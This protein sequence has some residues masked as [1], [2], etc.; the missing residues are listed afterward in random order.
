V[1]EALQ[2]G[3]GPGAERPIDEEALLSLAQM[4]AYAQGW[5][6]FKSFDRIQNKEYLLEMAAHI[7]HARAL[8]LGIPHPPLREIVAGLT[9]HVAELERRLK[10]CERRV[11]FG[12]PK[13]QGAPSNQ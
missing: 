2:P 12:D 1:D 6:W 3:D 5:Y 7:E 13:H 9:L 11:T 8:E 10:E 4:R